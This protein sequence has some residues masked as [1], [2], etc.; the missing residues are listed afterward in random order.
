MQ[1][2]PVWQNVPAR[3]RA[4]QVTNWLRS[5]WISPL[6]RPLSPG[7]KRTWQVSFDV[8][9]TARISVLVDPVWPTCRPR[10]AIERSIVLT[11]ATNG[12]P[13]AKWVGILPVVVP[14]SGI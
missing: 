12:R 10:R 9:K 7:E 11:N 13:T 6:R 14:L 4:A 1:L 2:A 3:I 8:Q 5:S